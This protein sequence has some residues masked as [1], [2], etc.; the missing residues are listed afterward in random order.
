M[1]LLNNQINPLFQELDTDYL[2]HFGLDTNM[3]LQAIFG[4]VKYIIITRTNEHAAIIAHKFGKEWYKIKE[5]FSFTPQF[6]TERFNLYKAGPVLAISYGFGMPSMLI[7]L[8]EISKLLVHL[9][10]TDVIAFKVGPAGGLGL[11]TGSLVVSQ[12]ALSS[13]LEAIHHTIECGDEY[14]YSTTLDQDIVNEIVAYNQEHKNYNLTMGKVLGSFDF[15]EEQGRMDGFLPLPYTL[16]ERDLY[17]ERACKSGVKCI[18]MES[19]EF[20]GFCNQV[21][22]RAGIVN[23]VVVNRFV[24]DAVSS[25][26]TNHQDQ[27]FDLISG[28]I[29]SKLSKQQGYGNGD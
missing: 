28:Y 9:N 14:T 12:E 6:K 18:D 4:D 27:A 13:R 17:F 3:D 26:D 7:C 23:A 24:K 29:I 19:L 2:Y 8:N 15:F 25:S 1:A 22:I 16:E 20:A 11:D 5:D 21:G 10:K